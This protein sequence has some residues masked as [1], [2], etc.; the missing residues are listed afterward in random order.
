[1][2]LEHVQIPLSS[3]FIPSDLLKK[4]EHCY[5]EQ[6]CAVAAVRGLSAPFMIILQVGNI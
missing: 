1:M 2:C 5:Q 4:K 3:P 6:S